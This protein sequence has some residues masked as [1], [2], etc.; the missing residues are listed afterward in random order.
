MIQNKVE[1]LV[2][3]FFCL[4]ENQNILLSEYIYP[5]Q[6]LLIKILKALFFHSKDKKEINGLIKKSATWLVKFQ[7]STFL[8]NIK[9]LDPCIELVKKELSILPYLTDQQKGKIIKRLKKEIKSID[10]LPLVLSS[11]DFCPRNIL[12]DSRNNVVT[13]DWM[14]L[15]KTHA[16]YD[17]HYFLIN[18]ESRKRHKFL[19]DE[20]YI[21]TLENIFIKTFKEQTNFEFSDEIYLLTR[22]L[23]LIHYLYNFYRNNKDKIVT[24]KKF[25]F[26]E[27]NKRKIINEIIDYIKD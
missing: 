8:G 2:P 23:Y 18:L 26:W 20:K 15:I 6:K 13:V 19:F 22:K 25:F 7:K 12:I 9:E 27:Y 5:S 3:L 10:K 24:F 1:G 14:S 21:D 16:Y 11:T 17:V 4:I